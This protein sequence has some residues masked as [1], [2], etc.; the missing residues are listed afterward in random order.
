MLTYDEDAGGARFAVT[1]RSGGVSLPPYDGL[2]LADHVGDDPACVAR[3]RALLAP[4]LGV[5]AIAW[6]HQVHGAEVAVVDGPGQ[7][8][9]ADGLVTRTRGLALAV[10]VADC[11]PVLVADPLAGVV[12]VAHAGRKGLV[13]AVV[14]ALLL[15]MRELGAEDLVA[16]VGPSICPRCYPVPEAMRAEVAGARPEA[17]SV[18]ATGEPSLDIAAGVVR[19]LVEGGA[20]VRWL[21]GCSAEDPELYSYRASGGTTGRY[22]GLAWLA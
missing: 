11:T 18:S 13:D 14:P 4:E 3:N 10:L 20:Q 5:D 7:Q 22:A 1:G 12:G 8:V 17:W 19:Q 15:A 9:T 21:P 6:M 16:R 2:N